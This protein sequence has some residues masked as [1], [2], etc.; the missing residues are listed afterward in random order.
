MGRTQTFIANSCLYVGL[1]VALVALSGCDGVEK[2]AFKA[3]VNAEIKAKIASPE[4]Q[5]ALA[6]DIKGKIEFRLEQELKQSV[7]QQTGGLNIGMITLDT[8][9]LTWLSPILFGL[10][11]FIWLR[12]R[13]AIKTVDMLVKG[14]DDEAI[15]RLES[16]A[17]A[18]ERFRSMAL[19][20]GL[21]KFLRKRIKKVRKSR[22]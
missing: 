1:A 15:E 2:D 14:I 5:A 11:V 16:P 4:F 20:R 22:R 12:K 6:R 19:S 8:S 13:K 10:L 18:R 21:E 3:D 17:P 7:G 9:W